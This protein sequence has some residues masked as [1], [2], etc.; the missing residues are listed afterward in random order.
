MAEIEKGYE[1]PEQDDFVAPGA[2][3]RPEPEVRHDLFEE[4]TAD[5]R[6]PGPEIVTRHPATP[7]AKLPN[8]L[9]KQFPAD[10]I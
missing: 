6:K 3:P 7:S 4:A 5:A 1:S 2:R 10:E 8:V 9:G